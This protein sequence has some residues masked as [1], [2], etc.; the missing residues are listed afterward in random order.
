MNP[1]RNPSA[2]H[3]RPVARRQFVQAALA[4]ALF[5]CLMPA[6]RGQHAMGA[7]QGPATAT[8]AKSGAQ[9][10]AVEIRNFAFVPAQLTVAVGTRVVWTNRDDEAHL[11]VNSNGAFKPSPALDTDDSYAAVFDKPGRYDYF[12]SIHPMMRGTVVVQ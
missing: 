7:A 5:A 9:A 12:C 8:A 2:R 3:A 11:V 6:A 10:G 4:A 1:L